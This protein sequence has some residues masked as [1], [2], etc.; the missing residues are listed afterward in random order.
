MGRLLFRIVIAA[1]AGALL[2]PS[3]APGAGGGVVLR[4]V[5]SADRPIGFVTAPNGSFFVIEQRGKIRRFDGNRVGDAILD[6]TKEISDGNE[7]GLLG[8]AFA[9]DGSWLYVNLTN[10]DGDT[11]IRAY[12]W[13]NDAIDATK[14]ILLLNVKQPYA[15]HNGGGLVVDQA[16]VLWIGLGDG[17][18]AGDPENRAQNLD[19]LLGKI[20]RIVPTPD[21]AK[22]YRIPVGNLDAA[23]GRP[24]IWA[25]GL[26]NPWRFSID[27]ATKR[28][29]IG[30]VGQG[31][32]EEIDTVPVD[33]VGANFGWRLR[34][35][36]RAYNGGAKPNSNVD[37]VH[38]YSHASGGCSVT[39]GTVYR[40]RAIASLRAAY[41]FADYCDGKIRLARR[42]A[43][44]GP[45]SVKM[46]GLI[47]L[48]LSSF[49]ADRDGEVYVASTD[50]AIAKIVAR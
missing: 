50:G 7:Q 25:W 47:L 16:G 32:R 17:G 20:L 49:G 5:A 15:N 41:L 8:A 40:G 4:K 1:F 10:I 48:N 2:M 27:S 24:E 6:V 26:R 30:D 28:I 45:A 19:T 13:V 21:E 33:T 3:P 11:E 39:G 42:S 14:M 37:P 9:N 31:D 23:R 34:E 29:W 46:S 12:P 36:T 38:D 18:S 43:L 44:G 35:G 22:P